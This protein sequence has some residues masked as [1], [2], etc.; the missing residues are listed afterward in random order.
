MHPPNFAWTHKRQNEAD[1]FRTFPEN[2]AL[3]ADRGANS[4]VKGR[5]AQED[6]NLEEHIVPLGVYARKG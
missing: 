4:V 6:P 5:N 2:W 3:I 1:L